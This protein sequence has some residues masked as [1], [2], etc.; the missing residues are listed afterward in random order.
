MR[1]AYIRVVSQLDLQLGLRDLGLGSHCHGDDLGVHH[2]VIPGG[3]KVR[4]SA[5]AFGELHYRQMVSY[6]LSPVEGP[7]RSFSA[8]ENDVF[9]R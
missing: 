6:R 8:A 4:K 7:L 1:G 3:R 5:S 2:R 9:K